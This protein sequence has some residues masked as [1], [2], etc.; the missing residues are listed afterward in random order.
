MT[1]VVVF[2]PSWTILPGFFFR[3]ADCAEQGLLYVLRKNAL[4]QRK[5]T[6]R[7][8]IAELNQVDLYVHAYGWLKQE[9]EDA[10]SI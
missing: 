3:S 8:L 10:W 9:A 4:M 1:L 7:K 5:Q 2:L 6:D